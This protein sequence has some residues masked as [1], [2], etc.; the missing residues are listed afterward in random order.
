[1]FCDKLVL[2]VEGEMFSYLTFDVPTPV[3][4]KMMYSGRLFQM[5]LRNML[6]SSQSIRVKMEVACS[7]ESRL[8]YI[9]SKKTS[10]EVL[11]IMSSICVTEYIKIQQEHG[12]LSEY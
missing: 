5:F 6:L 9:T 12:E 3:A 10:T 4:V 8:H 1:M 11:I 2:L 7:S